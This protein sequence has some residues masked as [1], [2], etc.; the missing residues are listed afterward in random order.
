MIKVALLVRVALS[1]RVASAIDILSSHGPIGSRF[2]I[3][4][5]ST[6]TT[7]S[8]EGLNDSCNRTECLIRLHHR[9]SYVERATDGALVNLA[10]AE[11]PPG[12]TAGLTI[13]TRL[14]QNGS[15][16]VAVV[17]AGSFYELGNGNRSQ[18]PHV[19]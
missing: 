13:A 5:E 16:S 3:P 18:I 9:R 11:V 19:R 8:P 14:A 6:L 7:V 17:E 12:G 4:G 15:F 1:I 10:R 2:G